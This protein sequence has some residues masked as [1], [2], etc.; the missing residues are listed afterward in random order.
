MITIFSVPK[1]FEGHIG[2]I[3]RNALDSWR[4]LC[5]DCEIILFGEDKGIEKNA[6]EFNAIH[7]KNIEVNAYNTPFL[8]TI[9]Y[10]VQSI[11]KNDIICYTNADILFFPDLIKTIHEIPLKKYLIVGQCHNI[12]INR[13]M[14][15]NNIECINFV[16]S[17]VKNNNEYLRGPGAIDY[18]IFNKGVLKQMPTFLVGRAGWDNW[19]I[20]H[21]QKELKIPVIDATNSITAIHQ[22]HDYSHIKYPSNFKWHGPES[23][24][25]L[26]NINSFLKLYNI[27]DSDYCIKNGIISKNTL[28]KEKLGLSLYRMKMHILTKYFHSGRIY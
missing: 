6:L 23:D 28:S 13:E 3:Q 19:M 22:N 27:I 2:I 26:N 1:P 10:K 20:Y 17:K 4:N 5:P 15:Y 18:F 14:N 12:N 7:E 9:F 25:N 24:E 11:A 21:F 16:K 8:N